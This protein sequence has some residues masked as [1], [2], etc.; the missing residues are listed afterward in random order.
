[1]ITCIS[2]VL[3]M[4]S[5]DI[6]F[7][8]ADHVHLKALALKLQLL[9]ELTAYIGCL[10]P[11]LQDDPIDAEPIGKGNRCDDTAISQLNSLTELFGGSF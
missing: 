4:T 7:L 1:M 5:N 3:L 2:P 8:L 11:S 6:S 10:A 9:Q